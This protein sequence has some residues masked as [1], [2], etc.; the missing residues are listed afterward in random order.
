MAIV[1]HF[2]KSAVNNRQ[3]S[4]LSPFFSLISLAAA[5]VSGVCSTLG[6]STTSSSLTAAFGAGLAFGFIVF[7]LLDGSAAGVLGVESF[8]FV[9]VLGV[10]AGY[11]NCQ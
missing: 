2:V 7:F 9:P 11:V 8:S 10:F 1:E 3:N 4:S 5:G 6:V